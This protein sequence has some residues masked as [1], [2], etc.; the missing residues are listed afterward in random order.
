MI[1][2][3]GTLKLFKDIDEDNIMNGFQFSQFRSFE[4]ANGNG[5]FYTRI[6]SESEDATVIRWMLIEHM[7][8]YNKHEIE[9]TIGRCKMY[10]L[11][12]ISTF[13][14]YNAIKYFHAVI[15]NK[16]REQNIISNNFI[17]ILI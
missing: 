16:G 3:L 8:K 5:V 12:N 7:K 14:S 15:V 9:E 13:V 17:Y 1:Q 2:A 6:V 11:K 4:D 10:Q